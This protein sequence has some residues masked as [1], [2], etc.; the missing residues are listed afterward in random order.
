AREPGRNAGVG[1]AGQDGGGPSARIWENLN[2][3][4]PDQPRLLFSKWD[5]SVVGQKRKS[6]LVMMRSALPPKPH[7]GVRIHEY[8]A[9]L[10]EQYA[11]RRTPQRRELRT[12]LG[13]SHP[14]LHQRT[15]IT[16]V[17]PC[18][19]ARTYLAIIGERCR[20]VI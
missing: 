17:R 2:I 4:A 3:A 7:I 14:E 19:S 9:Q 20:V 12:P 6:C 11:L 15:A 18:I 13:A 5:M 8:A 1:E 10:I 16:W